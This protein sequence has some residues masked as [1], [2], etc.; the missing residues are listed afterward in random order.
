[1]FHLFEV[2]LYQPFL[3]LLIGLYWLLNVIPNTQVDMGITV[4]IFTIIVRILLLPVSLAAHRSEAERR[5]ISKDIAEMEHKYKDNPIA[6][7]EETKKVLRGNRT[8]LVAEIVSLFIQV[9]ISLILW[10]I[11]SSGLEGKDAHLVYSFMPKIFP[12]PPEKLVFMSYSLNEPHWQL[13]LLQSFLIFILESLSMY[14]SPYPVQK[15]DVVRYQFFLPVVSF[16][17]FAFLP[18]GKKLFV[19]TTLVFSIGLTIILAIRKKVYDISERL[20][21]KDE[22]AANPPEEKVVVEVK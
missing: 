8:V 4:I 15:G 5:K 17:I 7:K 9:S 1:M 6:A 20:R 12:I 10:A 2:V 21:A 14:I 11:F 19:I 16:M 18:A 13:N 3:N 22:A